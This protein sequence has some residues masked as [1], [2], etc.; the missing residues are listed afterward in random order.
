MYHDHFGDLIKHHEC[1][2]RRPFVAGGGLYLLNC[3]SRSPISIEP[4]TSVL[5]RPH[6]HGGAMLQRD[7]V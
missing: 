2:Y 1:L 3:P 4:H 6:D 7:R 5:G